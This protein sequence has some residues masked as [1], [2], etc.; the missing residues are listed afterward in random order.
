[1]ALQAVDLPF[2]ENIVAQS[3]A[4]IFVHAP[5]YHWHNSGAGGIHQE[6]RERLVA[7]EALVDRFGRQT[8]D[9]EEVLASRVDAKGAARA[10]GLAEFQEFRETCNKQ[11]GNQCIFFTH[12]ARRVSNPLDSLAW[13]ASVP[14][15]RSAITSHHSLPFNVSHQP[16]ASNTIL[17]RIPM[18]QAL[19]RIRTSATDDTK[20]C[21]PTA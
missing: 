19:T 12:H 21:Q 15:T 18:P 8:E 11:P 13:L 17:F 1:M 2:P 3:G 14:P 20:Y 4:R 16:L 10:Q 5:Q 9:R 7:L 6:A